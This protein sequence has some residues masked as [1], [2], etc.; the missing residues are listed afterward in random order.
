MDS[1]LER[2]VNEEADNAHERFM[3]SP[4]DGSLDSMPDAIRP[5]VARIVELESERHTVTND[6]IKETWRIL[7]ARHGELVTEAA[8]RVMAKLRELEAIH[9]MPAA[10]TILGAAEE[11]TAERAAARMVERVRQLEGVARKM[12]ADND[13][14]QRMLANAEGII[15]DKDE[16]ISDLITALDAERVAHEETAQDRS[17]WRIRSSK[18]ECEVEQLTAQLS[19][20]TITIA[21]QQT[22]I[23]ELDTTV[24]VLVQ[25]VG[26]LRG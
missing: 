9:E 26:A 17:E 8:R 10:R 4:N 25:R 6:A 14:A 15:R 24:G 5:L 12:V 19:I 16:R 20:A 18:N 13:H 22:R 3:R 2:R 1:E 11:E 7:G 21:R 23:A